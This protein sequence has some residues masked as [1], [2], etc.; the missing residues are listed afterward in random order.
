VS[1][2]SASMN[3]AVQISRCAVTMA[4]CFSWAS[5]ALCGPIHDATRKGDEAKVI[6]LLNENP[7]LVS[8]RD[9]LGNTPLHIAA[10][11]D[12]T[13]IAALLI[14]NGADVNAHN[15]P[16]GHEVIASKYLSQKS[17]ADFNQKAY[18]E[19]PLTLAL[20]SYHHKEMIE[21]LLT[22]GA[23]PN[24]YVHI[25]VTPLQRAIERDLPYDV[26]LLLAN[27]ADPDAINLGGSSSV[28]WAVMHGKNRILELLL[29][30]GANPNA[31]DGAGHT[32][33]FY[34][35]NGFGGMS[36]EKAVALLH[37]HGGHE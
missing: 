4:L 9:N 7:D 6:A 28:L 29:N 18:G 26:E 25:G 10:L 27:G 32:P 37:A 21:L 2:R 12:Q 34:A 35:E 8:S 17:D 19:T 36:N 30:A 33:M 20:L 31:K 1:T 5:I 16:P 15:T 11:H 14:A 23:D 13:A 3:I 24:A 22:H